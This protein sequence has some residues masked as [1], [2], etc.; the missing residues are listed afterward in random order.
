M[1][2]VRHWH[3]TGNSE[4]SVP[5]K[6]TI[7]QDNKGSERP[8]AGLVHLSMGDR[9]AHTKRSLDSDDECGRLV[10]GDGLAT[11]GCLHAALT[12][13]DFAFRVRH[14]GGMNCHREGRCLA[15]RGALLRCKRLV[16]T[17]RR[18]GVAGQCQHTYPASKHGKSFAAVSPPAPD[19]V[20]GDLKTGE[21]W[22]CTHTPQTERRPPNRR[23]QPVANERDPQGCRAECIADRLQ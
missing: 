8:C 9:V 21:D 16:L 11:H 13:K 19:L 2:S 1:L 3:S 22:R 15:A 10:E 20:R 23:W 5:A 6:A 14:D 17:G 4:S 12:A 7:E 18:H